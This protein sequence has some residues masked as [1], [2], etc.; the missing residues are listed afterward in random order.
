MGG[1]APA[2]E[3]VGV[4]RVRRDG[5]VP[6]ATVV[7]SAATLHTLTVSPPAPGPGPVE[8]LAG[9]LDELDRRVAAFG[10]ARASLVKLVVYVRDAASWPLLEALAGRRYGRDCPAVS[11]VVVS[12][13]TRP[14]QWTEVAAWVATDHG[15]RPDPDGGIGSFDV[16][17]RLLASAGTGSIPI[18]IGGTA[19]EMYTGYAPP[20]TIEEHT[21]ISMRN[22]LAILEAAGTSLDRVFKSTWYVT[23]L[24]ERPGVEAVAREYFGRDLPAPTFVEISRLAPVGARLEPDLWADIPVQ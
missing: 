24:R 5:P 9:C 7:D 1:R 19:E 6:V 21:H 14:G 15:A 17:G 13:A 16:R 3:P 22:Q 2:R 23:D 20:A 4:R 8:E 18:F 12:K 11:P 10:A